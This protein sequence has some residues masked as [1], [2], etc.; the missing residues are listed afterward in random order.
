MW[1]DIQDSIDA[2]PGHNDLG[3][4]K[5]I[6]AAA[7]ESRHKYIVSR[8]IEL[9]N[10][11]FGVLENIEYPDEVVKALARLRTSANLL[12]PNFPDVANSEVSTTSSTFHFKSNIR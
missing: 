1:D 9:W 8:A 10:Q 4:L 3:K 12:L 6:L 7:L 2:R 11:R 5:T